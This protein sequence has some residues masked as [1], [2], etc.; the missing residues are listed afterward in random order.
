MKFYCFQV[1]LFMWFRRPKKAHMKQKILVVGGTGMLGKPVAMKLKTDGFQVV[2]FTRDPESARIKMPSSFEFAKGEVENVDSLM[3]AME[4]CDGVY[5][6]L[7][8]G[9]KGGDFDRVERKGTENIVL[10][11]NK[12]GVKK[13]SI[14]TGSSVS[15]ENSW[16]PMTKAKYYAEDAIR[17]SGIAYTIFRPSWFYESLPL[18]VR[19]GKPMAIGKSTKKYHWLAAEDYAA[20]VSNSFTDNATINKT[21]YV[22]GPETFTIREALET[23]CEKKY[24]GT[25]IGTISP[26][27]LS[28]IGT[29]TFNP[30]LKFASSF[31]RYSESVT[32]DADDS[33]SVQILGKAQT[34]IEDWITAN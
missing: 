23:Y 15:L 9:K 3:K 33:E 6:N 17:K 14:I 32:E 4:G 28:F 10:A 22:Y 24:P 2:V 29:I 11:A 19:D 21:L 8:G 5:I 20:M 7:H 18:F 16:Y 25:K 27:I 13:L 1:I 26:G 12:V 34:T 30:L 31:A